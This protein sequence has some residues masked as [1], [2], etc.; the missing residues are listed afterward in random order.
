MYSYSMRFGTITLN[1][2]YA[3]YVNHRN[4]LNISLNNPPPCR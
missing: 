2:H 4:S 3:S 1:I